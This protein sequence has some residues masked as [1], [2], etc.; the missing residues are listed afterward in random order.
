MRLGQRAVCPRFFR[1]VAFVQHGTCPCRA[2]TDPVW[3]S[4]MAGIPSPQ[5]ISHIAFV[6]LRREGAQPVGEQRRGLLNVCYVLKRGND[7]CTVPP[8]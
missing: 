6:R 1:R 3:S 8:G 2:R 5:V 4:V 7:A